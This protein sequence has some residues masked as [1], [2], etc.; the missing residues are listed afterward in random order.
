MVS[1]CGWRCGWIGADGG[2]GRAVVSLARALRPAVLMAQLVR[3][4]RGDEPRLLV[5][6]AAAARRLLQPAE[7]SVVL[8]SRRGYCQPANSTSSEAL[9]GV[10]ALT[11]LRRARLLRKA[12]GDAP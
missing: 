5:L 9:F 10:V 4:Q 3:A 7:Q 11:A 1:V 6:A 8:R 12:L 2:A